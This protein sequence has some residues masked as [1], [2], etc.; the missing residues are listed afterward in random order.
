MTPA[1]TGTPDAVL[2]IEHAETVDLDNQPWPPP[3]DAWQV[4]RRAGGCTR[5]CR[6]PRR[7]C[8]STTGRQVAGERNIQCHWARE[9]MAAVFCR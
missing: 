2:V 4:V 5:W 6:I 1:T 8:A 3:G 9:R 7:V